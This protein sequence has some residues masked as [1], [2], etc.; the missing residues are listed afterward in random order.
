MDVSLN[1]MKR[2]RIKYAK[3][4]ALKYTSG[5][6]VQKIWERS[7]RRGHLPVAYSQGFH[8][9]A[10][11]SQA[12]PLPLGF[13]SIAEWIDIWFTDEITLESLTLDLPKAVPPGIEILA[14]EEI[15]LSHSTMQNNFV[16]AT[17]RVI[18]LKKIETSELT[19]QVQHLLEKTGL[20]RIRRKKEYD[21]RPLIEELTVG[22][23]QDQWPVLWMKL[24]ARPGATGRPE[25]VMIELGLDPFES[26]IE[27]TE[28]FFSA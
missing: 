9:Q 5:L 12:A 18:V 10:R 26:R 16:A 27:K 20:P 22:E 3:I 6:E 17:Y 7:L 15:S 11:L 13:T 4:E 14:V 21:L 25:E 28:T 23:P 24:A 19:Q 8:P 1:T 2:F